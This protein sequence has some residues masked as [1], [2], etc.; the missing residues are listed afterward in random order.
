MIFVHEVADSVAM[1]NDRLLVIDVSDTSNPTLMNAVNLVDPGGSGAAF[2]AG[3]HVSVANGQ[4]YTGNGFFGSTPGLFA[5][6]LDR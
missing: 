3:A 4:I 6:G 5:I 2:S 1:E